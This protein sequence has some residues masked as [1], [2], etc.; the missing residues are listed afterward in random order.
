MHK[1]NVSH[2]NIL[3]ANLEKKPNCEVTNVFKINCWVKTV[4][5]LVVTKLWY[6][7][8]MLKTIWLLLMNKQVSEA[9]IIQRSWYTYRYRYI[10]R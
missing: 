3:M 8:T 9:K 4:I 6:K 7:D 2:F 10:S 1:F 5:S